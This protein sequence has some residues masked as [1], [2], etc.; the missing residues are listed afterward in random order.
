MSECPLS[1]GVEEWG[2]QSHPRAG[3]VRAGRCLEYFA[4][5]WNSLEELIAVRL[6]LLASSVTL[7][8]FVLDGAIQGCLRVVF[9]IKT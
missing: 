8:G 2:R 1:L 3:F 6:S 9:A 4:I 7:V 5:A